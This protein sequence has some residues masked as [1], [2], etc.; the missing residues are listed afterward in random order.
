QG[1]ERGMAQ[2][3]ERGMAQGIERGMAQGIERG[4][5]EGKLEGNLEGRLETARN[6]LNAGMDR[7]TVLQMTG[8]SDEQLA[9]L[10]H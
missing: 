6:M 8:L 3:I 7:Q 5:Q 10:K 9:M 4:K 1:I 2:G